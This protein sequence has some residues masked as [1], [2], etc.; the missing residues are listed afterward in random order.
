MRETSFWSSP[1]TVGKAPNP[2]DLVP[3]ESYPF[4]R[5]HIRHLRTIARL[6]AL[7]PAALDGCRVLELGGASGGNLIP[8]AIDHPGSSFLGI[9]LSARQIEMGRQQITDLGLKNIELRTVSIMDV[10]SSFGEFDYII[11]HGVLSWVPPAV[12][13][14]TLAICR[15]RLAPR[16]IAVVSY[17][18]LPGWSAWHSLRQMILHHCRHIGDPLQ[19]AH[20]ARRLLD[21]L[22][23]AGRE[24]TTPYWQMLR[25]EID[26]MLE[27][28]DWFLLHDHLEEDNTA[29]YLHQFIER[30]RGA[31]LQYLGEADLTA[32]NLA[33]LPAGTAGMVA[34]GDVTADD[35]GEDLIRRLQFLDLHQ[36]RRFRMSLLC[37]E[38]ETPDHGLSADR[39]WDFH[40]STGLRPQAQIEDFA[41]AAR[42]LSF[43]DPLGN[44][45]LR[46]TDPLS[47]AVFDTLCRQSLA[48]RP[49]EVVAETMRRFAINDGPG[50]RAALAGPALDLVMSN[51]IHL[52]GGPET[53]VATLSERP[54]A[55][56]LARYQARHSGWLTN[57][58]HEPVGVDPA[59]R[60]VIRLVDGRHSR[61]ALIESVKALAERGRLNLQQEGRPVTD[62]AAMARLIPAL[63]DQVLGFMARNA[64]LVA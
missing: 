29:F 1:D 15:E 18:T 32:M 50:L 5:S 31:G 47:T 25:D 60:E 51:A 40:W 12:Q 48:R 11:A 62:R 22:R 19:S 64:L 57:Q 54:M 23:R 20:Q 36:N 55:S 4:P 6:F 9:D 61:T 28:S 2:Y 17:N 8:M 49:E 42:P 7:T 13:E 38:T 14:K 35:K 26:R 59:A 58:R 52:H 39:L 24:E 3:Y 34:P 37:Q 45:R 33:A 10:D 46:T 44:S 16:G 56:R 27:L 30:V 63:V 41:G 21:S 53:W 43:L